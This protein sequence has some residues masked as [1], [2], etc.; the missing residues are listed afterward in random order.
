MRGVVWIYT[1]VSLLILCEKDLL[2]P[3]S[4]IELENSLRPLVYLDYR[5]QIHFPAMFRSLRSIE[6]WC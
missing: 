3:G 1:G 6:A 2:W 5:S 4:R